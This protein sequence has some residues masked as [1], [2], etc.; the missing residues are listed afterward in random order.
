ME[1]NRYVLKGRSLAKLGVQAL[2]DH[3]PEARIVSAERVTRGGIGGF[4]AREHF[5]VVVEVPAPREQ[6]S[7]SLPPPP[8]EDSRRRRRLRE[9]AQDRQTRGQQAQGQAPGQQTHSEDLDEDFARM[10]DELWLA[11]RNPPGSPANP[12]AEVRE[13][14]A[15]DPLTDS[16]PAVW[17][18]IPDPAPIAGV[19]DR[20]ATV[21]VPAGAPAAQAPEVLRAPGSL[22]VLACLG[23]DESAALEA[24]GGDPGLEAWGDP[25]LLAAAEYAGKPLREAKQVLREARA[26]AV[27]LQVPVLATCPVQFPRPEQ[28]SGAESPAFLEA[29]QLWAVVDLRRKPE[30]IRHW[31]AALEES[32]AIDGLVLTCADETLSPETGHQLGWPVSVRMNQC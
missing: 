14:T 22:I 19:G 31:L 5:E 30:D 32:R 15:P 28:R 3:G 23:A 25:V 27:A 16:R 13:E 4:M 2:A 12:A 10:M 21:P 24:I 20:P 8:E 7:P 6:H 1:P 29:D 11:S 18:P 9:E 26:R 17:S